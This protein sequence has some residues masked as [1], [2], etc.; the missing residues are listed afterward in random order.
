M[1]DKTEQQDD[2]PGD[3]TDE[4]H[5]PLLQD[6]VSPGKERFPSFPDT[7]SDTTGPEEP[8]QAP[9]SDIPVSEI[10]GL[11]LQPLM[12]QIM[13]ELRQELDGRI[14]TILSQALEDT[15]HSTLHRYEMRL[16]QQIMTHLEE[17][18]PEMIQSYTQNKD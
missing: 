3:Q 14:S 4:I 5:V 1:N 16:Q 11:E 8:Q 2:Q 7:P 10:P 9:I 15:L 18:L 6:I 17:H 13:Q 12:E